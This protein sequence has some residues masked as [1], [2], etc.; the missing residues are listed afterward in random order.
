MHQPS[1]WPIVHG[2]ALET[3]TLLDALDIFWSWVF[4]AM[5]LWGKPHPWSKPT[6]H[7]PMTDPLWPTCSSD[8]LSISFWITKFPKASWVGVANHRVTQIAKLADSHVGW[9]S[10]RWNVQMISNNWLVQLFKVPVDLVVI[11]LIVV[12]SVNAVYFA[13]SLSHWLTDSLTL[14]LSLSASG[15]GAHIPVDMPKRNNLLD[16]WVFVVQGDSQC[17]TTPGVL[18]QLHDSRCYLL[19][20]LRSLLVF[21]TWTWTKHGPVSNMILLPCILQP[22]RKPLSSPLEF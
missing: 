15:S 16:E 12:V 11:V 17:P 5:L 4:L 22:S 19:K 6:N 18:R 8:T 7:N 2:S 10:R 21:V 9:K 3:L 20:N 14:S 1:M 13:C